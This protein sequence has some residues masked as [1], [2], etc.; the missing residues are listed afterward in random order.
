[1]YSLCA[2]PMSLHG[3]GD[4]L[5]RKEDYPMRFTTL[6]RARRTT[7]R[8]AQRSP[9]RLLLE[10]LEDRVV[11]TAPADGTLLVATLP[12]Q[13]F[14]STDQSQFPAGIIG[15]NPMT[16]AQSVVSAGGFFVAPTYIAEDTNQQLYVTDVQ[17]FPSAELLTNL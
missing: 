10:G 13:G 5:P 2:P 1:P 12:S 16:G 17:A 4:P 8:Q 7:P 6:L 11:P 9:R 3:N 15:V 14:A